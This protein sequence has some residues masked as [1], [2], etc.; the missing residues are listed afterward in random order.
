MNGNISKDTVLELTKL[1]WSLLVLFPSLSI[2][3]SLWSAAILVR[4]PCSHFG[5]YSYV[6]IVYV[7]QGRSRPL[8]P[9]AVREDEVM[10]DGLTEL[11]KHIVE[12]CLGLSD[13]H[14]S[15][16][17]AAGLYYSTTKQQLQQT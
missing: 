6:R 16:E 12:V 5:V 11:D 17:R 8:S 3:H 15:C 10:I 13:P 2:L 1:S 9:G 4:R 7:G 14:I